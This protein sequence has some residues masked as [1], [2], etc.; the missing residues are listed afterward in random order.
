MMTE[1]FAGKINGKQKAIGFIL[2]FPLYLYVIPRFANFGIYLLLKYTNITR[3]TTILGIYLNLICSL[4]SFVLV[5]WLLKDFLIDN[6]KRF[7]EHFTDNFVYSITIGIVMIYGISIVA[8]MIINFVL[9]GG[10]NDSANQLLFEDYL[11]NGA[12][13]MAFQSVVLAPILEELLFRGLV[14]RSLRDKSKWLAIFASS[15]LF[16]FLH[17][18]SALFAGDLSQLIYLLSYGGM[19]FAFSYAYEKRKTICVPI[20]MHMINNLV[21]IVLLVF[22]VKLRIPSM[23]VTTGL[24]LIYE[25]VANY[26][27][28][29]VEQTLPSNLRAFG[30]MPWN[31][32]LAL[33]ACVAAYIFL[34]YTKIGTYTYAIGSNEFV[35]KNMGINVNKYKVLAFILSGAFLGVMAILTISYGSSMVA[36]TGMASMSR[37]F[38]PTMGCFFGLAFK[39]YGMP[40][41]AIVIGE[42]VI[43]IIFFGF[44]AMGA[45]TAI[46]DVI[47]GLALLIII[48]L[49][50]KAEKGEIVK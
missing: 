50:T 7:K 23:I 39:K 49:T 17:I 43:N 29:G 41:Q 1:S 5:V 26:I 34:N 16:G 2:L 3:D 32:I 9:G 12:L 4:L 35:A 47:T 10:S 38:V 13:L 33:L 19:G 36:V 8:N 42:F 11:N 21:A 45:P 48:T 24:A 20:L 40:L 46:Q 37:N 25:S 15:F 6:I 44:I 28:G 27:A 18:Y 22:Y 14:F 30:Q 31:I